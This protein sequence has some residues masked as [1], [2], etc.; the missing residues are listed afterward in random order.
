MTSMRKHTQP[1]RLVGLIESAEGRVLQGLAKASRHNIVEIGSHK[2]KSTAYLARGAQESTDKPVVYAVDVW[3]R[4]AE[5][6]PEKSSSIFND[7][8][9]FNTWEDQMVRAGVRQVI[10]PLEMSSADAREEF[11]DDDK[12]GLLF[13]DAA[14]DYEN[15]LRDFMLWSP[16]VVSG[17]IVAFHDYGNPRWPHGVTRVVNEELRDSDSY[18]DFNTMGTLAWA[19]KR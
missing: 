4:F 17:G 3:R 13:I 19:T 12:F 6:Y 5:Y 7:P 9:I 14:H 10:H 18:I 11:G 8:T 16:L 15:A 2:G 1:G